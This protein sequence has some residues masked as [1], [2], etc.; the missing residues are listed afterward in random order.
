MFEHI[1]VP[2]DGSELAERVLPCAEQMARATGAVL[3]LVRVVAVPPPTWGTRTRPGLARSHVAL[4]NP[5]VAETHAAGVYLDGVRARL[6]TGGLPVRV[7]SLSGD[8][9]SR[10]L[11]YERTQ[12]IDLVTLCSHGRAGLARFALGSVAAR[13][14]HQSASPLLLVRAFGP[15]VDLTQAVVPLD[16]S[17]LAEATLP[18][19]E[20]LAGPLLSGVTLLRAVGTAREG[21]EAERYLDRIA[22]R[23]RREAAP[24][25]VLGAC[26]TR[27][28]VDDPAP[29]ILE[30][31]ADKVVITATHG[32]TGL[33]RWALG[34]VADQVARGGAAGVLAVRG[35]GAAGTPVTRS[36]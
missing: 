4:N 30:T 19:V 9:A 25:Q 14:L 18:V 21:L 23:L 24:L 34:S 27:V 16:G 3:H 6:V 13:L 33:M 36:P 29:L 35:D 1:L 32:R 22:E 8:T 26:R 12:G 28:V 5:L 11:A 20:A 7:A 31:A 15:P 10:L 17:R 2:L